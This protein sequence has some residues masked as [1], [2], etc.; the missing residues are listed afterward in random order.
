M[1]IGLDIMG[2]DKAP[3][4]TVL[5]ALAAQKELPVDCKLVL[6]GDQ[7]IINQLITRE[8]ADASKFEIIHAPDIISYND[9]PTRALAAKPDSSIARGFKLLKDGKID[10]FAGAGNT[11]AMLVGSIY[12]VSTVPGVIRPCITSILPKL[13]GTVGILLDVGANSDSK[14]DVL[15]QWA[16]LGSIYSEFVYGIKN[17]RVALLSI[18]EEEEKGNIVTQAA[19][20]L[21]KG[22]TDFNFVGNVEG[23]DLF[24]AKADIII[25]DGFTGNIILK[26]L[27]SI[28]YLLKKRSIT[29]E[30]FDRWNYELYGGT[31][32]LGINGNVIIGHG[33][34]NVTAIK[35]MVM[36]S[37]HVVDA[38]L[39]QKI[40][41]A[42]S[43]VVINN[44]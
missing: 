32:V 27:E 38:G 35:N 28:Y 30:Y 36:H 39:T 37:K 40:S 21:M 15:Y 13:D 25:T 11:G 22:T 26:N 10:V 9:H 1:K 7:Q 23:R 5:G 43:K 2:G 16:I 3:D 24:S 17:P 8:N 4:V 20:K 33:I 18:G 29:D 41:R 34:S 6:I 14:A 42:L 12:S 31:P 19:H 44:G